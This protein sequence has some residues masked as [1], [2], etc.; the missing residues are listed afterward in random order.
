[1]QNIQIRYEVPVAFVVTCFRVVVTKYG[2]GLLDHGTLKPA[3][4]QGN[5]LIK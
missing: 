2:R 1:M 5:E 4:S 3:I